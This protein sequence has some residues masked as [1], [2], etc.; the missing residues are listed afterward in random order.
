MDHFGP[1]NEAPLNNSG[2]AVSIFFQFCTLKG[3]NIYIKIF[4]LLMIF[5][6]NIMCGASQPFWGQK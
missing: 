2:S 4:I 5:P 1:R 3:A 6:K